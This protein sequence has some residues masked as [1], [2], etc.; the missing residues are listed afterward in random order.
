[1]NNNKMNIMLQQIQDMHEHFGIGGK[2]TD[3][4]RAF[5]I[6]GMKEEHQEYIDANT[7]ADK[8]DALI[9]LVVFTLGTVERHGWIDIFGE[10][11]TRVMRANCN[12]KVGSNKKRGSFALDLIKPE[13]WE[14]P[15]FDDLLEKPKQLTLDL[16]C[17]Q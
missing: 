5:R 1:M 12:K 3:E 10:A 9:D 8:L 13:N 17:E 7:D 15:N 6:S 2:I 11:F 14:A 16:D 4:E